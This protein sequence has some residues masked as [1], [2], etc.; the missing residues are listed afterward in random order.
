MAARPRSKRNA[1][2]PPYL[3]HSKER[4]FF[5]T[6]TN[7]KRITLSTTRANAIT[8]ANEY[9]RRARGDQTEQVV[10]RLMKATGSTSGVPFSRHIIETLEKRILSDRKYG[11]DT[12][13]TLLNDIDRAKQFFDMPAADINLQTVN[14][15]IETNHPKASGNVI[16]R[17]TGFLRMLFRF[18]IDE[19]LMQTNPA[20]LKMKRPVEKKQRQRLTISQF[21]AIRAISPSWLKTAMDL[22]LQTTHARL[23][24]TRIE[25]RL[26]RPT[27]GRCGVVWLNEPEITEEGVIYG[28]LYIHRQKVEKYEASHVAIPVGDR[29]KQ[30][31]DASRDELLSPYIVHRRREKQHQISQEVTHRTQIAPDYLSRA[32][33]KHRDKTGLFDLMPANQRPTFHE[34]RALAAKLFNDAGMDPQS[35]MAHTDAKSTKIYTQNHREWVQVPHGEIAV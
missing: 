22:S 7:G 13:K 2:L 30:I 1:G 9:N 34:I 11:T 17:K 33:S 4:G 31:I 15:Y 20:E 24:I 27:E 8:I 26:N 5:L 32:F 23:E 16:N 3:Y 21:K 12:L 14:S 25:Y 35:R 18:A 29:L 19:G 6:L 28:T 10:E